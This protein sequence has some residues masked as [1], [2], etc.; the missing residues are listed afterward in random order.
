MAEIDDVL[1]SDDDNVVAIQVKGK[2]KR[3]TGGKGTGKSKF[4]W[5]LGSRKEVLISQVSHLFHPI[6]DQTALKTWP[7]VLAGCLKDPN[8]VGVTENELS[9]QMCSRKFEVI[10]TL[11]LQAISIFSVKTF[12][13]QQISSYKLKK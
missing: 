10:N 9:S 4:N 7:L 3:A 13:T 2:G 12:I 6:R 5:D 1:Q 11:V 8:F